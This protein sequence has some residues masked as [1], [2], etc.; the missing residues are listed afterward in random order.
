MVNNGSILLRFVSIRH[1]VSR[2]FEWWYPCKPSKSAKKEKSKI[3]IGA[4]QKR[5]FRD[6]EISPPLL[7]KWFF[8]RERQVR[9]TRFFDLGVGQK[10]VGVG[11]KKVG[12]GQKRIWL[13]IFHKKWSCREFGFFHKKWS[14]P[15]SRYLEIWNQTL[16]PTGLFMKY[17][18]SNTTIA[19]ILIYSEILLPFYFLLVLQTYHFGQTDTSLIGMCRTD[20][21][22]QKWSIQV[23]SSD[24]ATT[25]VILTY[26]EYLPPIHCL[27]TSESCLF[28]LGFLPKLDYLCDSLFALWFWI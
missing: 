14:A 20:F 15:A 12:V 3:E 10:K 19:V 25:T 16:S 11:Q 4:H 22:F 26:S 8:W 23:L 2:R 28:S 13:G 5:G 9:K 6:I 21:Y 18:S 7:E 1:S 27:T 17:W 24:V